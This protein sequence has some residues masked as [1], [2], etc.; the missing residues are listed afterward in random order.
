MSAFT[1][2]F[3]RKAQPQITSGCAPLSSLPSCDRKL[4]SLASACAE[5]I[6][7]R[8]RY[9]I[10]AFVDT[11]LAMPGM[12]VLRIA[13]DSW[14]PGRRLGLP[15]PATRIASPQGGQVLQACIW[16]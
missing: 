5:P 10:R 15:S 13:R 2:I 6:T 11:P 12:A 3:D 14:L 9:M 16:P 1:R 7:G 8:W 4:M